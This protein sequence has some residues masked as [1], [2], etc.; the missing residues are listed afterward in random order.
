MEYFKFREF[1]EAVIIQSGRATVPHDF[2]M[3][4][5]HAWELERKYAELINILDSEV[6]NGELIGIHKHI[7]QSVNGS[8]SKIIND[9]LCEYDEKSQATN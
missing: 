6:T 3:V 9:F 5:R 4:N 1:L 8:F 2:S 7:N